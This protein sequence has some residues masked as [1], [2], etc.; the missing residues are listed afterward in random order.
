[1]LPVTGAPPD[2]TMLKALRIPAGV[3]AIALIL[4]AASRAVRD[5]T[6]A[7]FVYEN[8]IWLQVRDRL[9]LPQSKFLRGLTLELVGL[10]LLA[11]VL[12]TIRYVFPT[13]K[14][15]GVDTGPSRPDKANVSS[16]PPNSS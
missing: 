11:G 8:C 10:A 3:H 14:A 15:H 16:N 4:A 5:C 12:L 9:H 6:V 7:P 1:V 2:Q 13:R